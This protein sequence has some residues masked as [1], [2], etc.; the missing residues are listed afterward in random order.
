MSEQYE[1]IPY[2]R[3][4]Y[5]TTE[6]AKIVETEADHAVHTKAGWLDSPAELAE[7]LAADAKKAAKTVGKGAK[8]AGV[9]AAEGAGLVA[10]EVL[11][12]AAVR[13]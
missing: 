12:G 7:K 2:P 8:A 3:W 13:D 6:A 5:H 10:A 4:I 1:P 11:G 9:A